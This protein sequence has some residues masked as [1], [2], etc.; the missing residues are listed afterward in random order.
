MSKYYKPSFYEFK[1][2]FR[3]Q[4]KLPSETEWNDA[5]MTVDDFMLEGCYSIFTEIT[6]ELLKFNKEDMKVH[7]RVKLLDDDDI[8]E[9]GFK[10]TTP[11]YINNREFNTY[12]NA[13]QYEISHYNRSRDSTV[14]IADKHSNIL[15]SGIIMNYSELLEILERLEIESAHVYKKKLTD[16]EYE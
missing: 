10:K 2:G 14:T 11:V 8:L 6:N 16:L 9:L 4:H 13:Q 5:V 12:V 3:Y 1:P 15:F 7:Y